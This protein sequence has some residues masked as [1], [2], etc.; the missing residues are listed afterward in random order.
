MPLKFSGSG[1]DRADLSVEKRMWM[2]RPK[3]GAKI[4]VTGGRVP[5]AR[6]ERLCATPR[7]GTLSTGG[8]RGVRHEL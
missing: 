2:G 8:S 6:G 4:W 1:N 3:R 5:V 7:L